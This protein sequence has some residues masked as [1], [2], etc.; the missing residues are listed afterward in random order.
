MLSYHVVPGAAILS[1]DLT[2]G[3]IVQTLLE[4]PAGELKVGGCALLS[5]ERGST[6]LGCFQCLLNEPAPCIQT[7]MSTSSTA[8][9]ACAL[10]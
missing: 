3:A 7:F 1:G 6:G 5:E 9:P 2:D 8:V 10:P 4:G